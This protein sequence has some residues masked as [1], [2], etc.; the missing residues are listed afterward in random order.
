MSINP[1]PETID[2]DAALRL[3]YLQLRFP[4]LEE[5]ENNGTLDSALL[6]SKTPVHDSFDVQNDKLLSYECLYARGD[7]DVD[8]YLGKDLENLNEISANVD[9]ESAAQSDDGLIFSGG[10]VEKI[11]EC[12]KHVIN[13]CEAGSS[14]EECSSRANDVLQR[15]IEMATKMVILLILVCICFDLGQRQRSAASCF[16]T[17]RL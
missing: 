13:K 14:L 8:S 1:Q 17:G 6:E 15:S 3:R 2:R 16:K 5:R 12:F 4:D 9:S 11:G 10:E 7:K